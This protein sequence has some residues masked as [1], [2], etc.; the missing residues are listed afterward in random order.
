[1]KKLLA[2]AL[3]SM[4]ITASADPVEDVRQTELAFAKAFADRDAARFFSFVADD[5]TFLSAGATSRGKEQVVAS[6]SRFFDGPAAPFSWMPERVSVS[7]DGALALST[8]PVFVPSG[9]HAGDF[10][11]TW[12]KN[13]DGE[14]KVVFDS[15]GPG[16][17]ARA[18]EVPAVEEGTIATPD[19][20][21]LHYRRV[22]SRG[23]TLV[24]P[25]DFLLHDYFRQFADV[26]TVITYD[27]RNRGRSSRVADTKTLTIQQDVAD[28]ETVRAHFN[29]DR[30]VPVGY[31]YLGK[32]VAMYAAAHPQRVA[33]VVQLAPAANTKEGPR[34]PVGDFG[35]AAAD[36][37]AWQKQRAEGAAAAR[38]REFCLVQWNVFRF[39]MVGDPA[40]AARF[41]VAETCALENEW[42]VNFEAH[43]AHHGPTIDAA[44]L[45]DAELARISMPV[46]VVHGTSDR[47]VPHA[48][49]KAWSSSLPQAR[50]VTLPGAAHAV[51]IDAPLPIFSALRTFLRGDWPMGAEA[52]R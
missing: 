38:P 44:A 34:G 17:A 14:W 47:N 7:A 4:A 20:A 9:R 18:E 43:M 3:V 11:S 51:W 6:W 30:I 16:A 36:I 13:A 21:T 19:G 39:Y 27:T 41:P 8:G 31:S 26:A 49:G 42:P 35:A 12:R 2:L 52:T 48:S 23:P 10:I 37:E 24:V 22:G 5:A 45:S 50:L 33:R 32:V 40:N 1:M 46:L 15:S 29:A 28:L 25:L